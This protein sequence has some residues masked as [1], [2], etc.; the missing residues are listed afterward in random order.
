MEDIQDLGV[1]AA[2]LKAVGKCLE[3]RYH[4]SICI[5]ALHRLAAGLVKSEA[6]MDLLASG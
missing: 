6:E 4:L 2:D 5:V 3:T 1:T